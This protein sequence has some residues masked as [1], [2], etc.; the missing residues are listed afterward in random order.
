MR[1]SS[2]T[3]APGR[4]HDVGLHRLAGVR[5]GHADHGDASATAGCEA[6]H[7][8]DL[9]RVHVEA[10]HDDEVLGPVDEEQEAVV[11]DHG[12]VAGVQ[13]AVRRRRAA[14]VASGSFQ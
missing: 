11:V 4:D 8:L 9:G 3:R 12:D 2:S 7:L 6:M 5:V 10:R 1:S 14:R 13:P